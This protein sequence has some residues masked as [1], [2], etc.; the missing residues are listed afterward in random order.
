[1]RQ[2]CPSGWDSSVIRAL[3]LATRIDAHR[4]LK[5]LMMTLGAP[6]WSIPALIDDEHSDPV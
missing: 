4:G 3:C 6:N 5:H 1:M 2:Q